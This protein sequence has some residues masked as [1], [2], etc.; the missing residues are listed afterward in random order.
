MPDEAPFGFQRKQMHQ[1]FGP[2]PAPP[3]PRPRPGRLA[4]LTP[5]QRQGL[6]QANQAGFDLGAFGNFLRTA[7]PGQLVQFGQQNLPGG[8]TPPSLQDLLQGQ[9]GT[10]PLLQPL[11]FTADPIGTAERRAQHLLEQNLANIGAQFTGSGLGASSR[12]DLLRGAAIGEASAS[13]GD[14][15]AQ[16]AL[17]QRQFEQGTFLNAL[18]AAG[19]QNL[20]EQ[21]A[22]M[23]FLRFLADAGGLL[24][25]IGQA[26]QTVPG[27]AGILQVLGLSPIQ[28]TRQG[29]GGF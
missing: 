26:E 6:R 28:G 14:V 12:N 1:G 5:A 8:A 9:F 2:P 25:N 15:I 19:A 10:S 11:P 7:P 23:D 27:L 29:S 3:G 24:T 18:A 20:Q 4:A 16:R 21:G 13:L 17:Q 22:A